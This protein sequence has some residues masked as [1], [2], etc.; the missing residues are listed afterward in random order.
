[1][2]KHDDLPP[3]PLTASQFGFSDTPAFSANQ[4]RRYARKALKERKWVPLTEQDLLDLYNK[5]T[6][7]DQW[8]Y[9]RAIEQRIK[10]KNYDKC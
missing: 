5:F 8:T 3:L 2:N 9:E 1:M 6:D 10:E 7:S 4:M